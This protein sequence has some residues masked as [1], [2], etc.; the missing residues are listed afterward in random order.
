MTTYQN[1]HFKNSTR[2]AGATDG[3]ELSN[4][5]NQKKKTEKESMV[6]PPPDWRHF[7]YLFSVAPLEYTEG[8]FVISRRALAASLV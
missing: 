5:K 7:F 3:P 8:R 4:M 6:S 2:T 1:K